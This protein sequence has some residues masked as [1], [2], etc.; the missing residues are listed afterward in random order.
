MKQRKKLYVILPLML[1]IILSFALAGTALAACEQVGE[2]EDGGEIV[3][4]TGE[5]SEGYSTVDPEDS[6]DEKDFDDQVTV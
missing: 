3:T 1:I 4:C 6:R 5:D 2:T